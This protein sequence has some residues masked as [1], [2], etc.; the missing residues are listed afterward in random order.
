[1]T[2]DS[3]RA[4]KFDE[5][6]APLYLIDKYLEADFLVE[7]SKVMEK[8]AEKYGFENWKKGQDPHRYISALRRHLLSFTRGVK[9]DDE[10]EVHMP[11][12]EHKSILPCR[13]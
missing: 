6:K 8:G 10:T 1:M 7:V 11:R 5:G 3:P 2:A 9:E 4:L 12:T 13:C